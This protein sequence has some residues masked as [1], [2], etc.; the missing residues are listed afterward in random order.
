M[1]KF[2]VGKSFKWLL[3]VF[4]LIVVAGLDFSQG[5]FLKGQSANSYT[6]EKAGG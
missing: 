1:I 2:F 4:E 5:L 6:A 3:F